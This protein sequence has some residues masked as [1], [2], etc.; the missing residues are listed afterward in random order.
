MAAD[1]SDRNAVSVTIYRG[2][3]TPVG[4]TLIDPDDLA[5]VSRN[6]W[7]LSH[8]GYAVRSESGEDGRQ[9]IYLHREIL[10]T[11]K[12]LIT[13]HINGDRL[14]NRRFNLRVATRGQ[15]NANGMDRSRRSGYR[16]VYW[17]GISSK[18]WVSQ[19]SVD[20]RLRHLGLFEDPREA[21]KTYDAAARAAWGQ[22][23]RTNG[24]A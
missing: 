21:A 18:R 19:I 16:G 11:P 8:H 10:G 24:F 1:G 12:G 5:K 14:D 22:F 17:H 20:G 23:A 3:G 7:R 4:Q 13:D 9:T 2:D 6:T 15:N